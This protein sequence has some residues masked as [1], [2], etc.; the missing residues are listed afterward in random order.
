MFVCDYGNSLI[1]R[2]NTRTGYVYTLRGEGFEKIKGPTGIALDPQTGA[3][4]VTEMGNHV[5]HKIINSGAIPMLIRKTARR[6]L[7]FCR[8]L[9]RHQLND[10]TRAILDAFLVVFGADFVNI[11]ELEQIKQLAGNRTNMGKIAKDVLTNILRKR[12]KQH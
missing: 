4:Y 11:S 7:R 8:I 6:L 5:I 1:R 9:N 12:H 2:I 3:L 10:R